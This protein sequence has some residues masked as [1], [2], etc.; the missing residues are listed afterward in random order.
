[1][2][3]F[4]LWFLLWL[5]WTL[6]YNTLP[7][8]TD[9]FKITYF[10]PCSQKMHNLILTFFGIYAR[11]EN[12]ACRCCPVGMTNI[13]DISWFRNVSPSKESMT[14]DCGSD[15]MNWNTHLLM[16]S[17]LYELFWTDWTWLLSKKWLH[18]SGHFGSTF[19]NFFQCKPCAGFLFCL[20]HEMKNHL[21]Q[22]KYGIGQA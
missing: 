7:K 20:M 15:W 8:H 4:L 5:C 6:W 22:V 11:N 13:I 3:L 2:I 19:N 21:S 17:L 10:Q 9:D 1:M 18:L 12:I 16:W 14:D